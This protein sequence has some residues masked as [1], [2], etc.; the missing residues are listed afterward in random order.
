MWLKIRMYLLVAILFAILY[1][2]IVGIGTWLGIG[3]AI[4]YLILAFV[5]MVIQYMVGPSIVAWSMKVKGL[6]KRSPGTA[7]DSS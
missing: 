5:F 6:G 7:P 3:G 4:P 2:V 1:G